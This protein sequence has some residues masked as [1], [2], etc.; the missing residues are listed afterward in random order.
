MV[1]FNRQ[2]YVNDF[3]KSDFEQDFNRSDFE[4]DFDPSQFATDQSVFDPSEPPQ[5][6]EP[7]D[8]TRSKVYPSLEQASPR[9]IRD[10]AKR[11][12]LPDN[13]LPIERLD[14][15]LHIVSDPAIRTMYKFVK[16]RLLGTPEV[17]WAMLKQILPKDMQKELKGKDLGTSIDEAL[18]YDPGR[19]MRF[20]G[21]LAELTGGLKT[22]KG[23]VGKM[24][25]P[26]GASQ[27]ALALATKFGLIS[28]GEEISKAVAGEIDPDTEFG[29]QGASM[30]LASMG[31]GVG[32]S[33]LSS[34]ANPTIKKLAG[35]TFG[36]AV[37]KA[38]Q[39]VTVK[40][41]AKWPLYADVI[42]KDPSASSIKAVL[43][44][45]K[46][47]TGKTAKDL[48]KIEKTAIKHVAR[49][50][51]R[52]TRI[53]AREYF[54]NVPPSVVRNNREA[55]TAI[56]KYEQTASS[57][58]KSVS[59]AVNVLMKS[60]ESVA[61]VT[62]ILPAD[63]TELTGHVSEFAEQHVV[64]ADKLDADG[65]LIKGFEGTATGEVIFK[66]GIEQVVITD[67]LGTKQTVPISEVE[68]IEQAEYLTID[69]DHLTGEENEI[70]NQLTS[71]QTKLLKGKD[72]T[73]SEKLTAHNDLMRDI[74]SVI[75]RPVIQD[76]RTGE[77][78]SEDPLTAEGVKFEDPTSE[79]ML[80]KT[81]DVMK[82][83]GKRFTP[84][85]ID[86][87]LQEWLK[88][89][90]GGAEASLG[91]SSVVQDA[92]R[93][94]V[95]A[96]L[97]LS[98]KP[99]AVAAMKRALNQITD[100]K[101]AAT[102]KKELNALK[103]TVH[104]TQK[105]MK[106]GDAQYRHIAFKTTGKRSAATMNKEQ[107]TEFN[108][109]LK[110]T[111]VT[112]NI[113]TENRILLA[114]DTGSKIVSPDKNIRKEQDIDRRK[115]MRNVNTTNRQVKTADARGKKKDLINKLAPSRVAVAQF[116]DK[117][118][119][120]V[121]Y[122]HYQTLKK[123]KITGHNAREEFAKI[124]AGFP[125]D[126]QLTKQ[127]TKAVMK[128]VDTLIQNTSIESNKQIANWLFED[129]EGRDELTPDMSKTDLNTAQSLDNI[130]QD[131][132]VAQESMLEAMRLWVDNGKMPANLNRT[133]D[134]GR[135]LFTKKQKKEMFDQA[136]A[137]QKAGRLS[138][139]S[140][141]M[142]DSGLRIG[143]RRYYYPAEGEH[144]NEVLDLLKNATADPIDS[145]ASAEALEPS[146]IS[147]KARARRGKSTPKT[148]SV[149]AN[150]MN[151]HEKTS[152]RNAV[153][154]D[155]KTLY[156]RYNKAPLSNKDDAYLNSLYSDV[157]LKGNLDSDSVM[158]QKLHA[159]F[160][161]THLSLVTN[162]YG[163]TKATIRNS[164]QFMAESGGATNTTEMLKT[165]FDIVNQLVR[166]NTLAQIDPQ[167]AEDFH[168]SFD[169]YISQ[170]GSQYKDAMFRDIDAKAR[171]DNLPARG[172]EMTKWLLDKTGFAY[173]G[174]DTVSRACLWPTVYK[175]TK[176][177][178]I[179][180]SKSAKTTKDYNKYLHKT[181]VDTMMSNSQTR[182][183]REL[184][185]SG[186]IRALSNYIAD[187]YTYDI[188][189]AYET[190]ERAGIERTRAQ[191]E[192]IGIYTYPRGVYDLFYNR[193]IRPMI[194]GIKDN[195][196]QSRA[197]ARRG[198][199]NVANQLAGRFAAN[200]ILVGLGLGSAYALGRAFWTPLSPALSITATGLTEIGFEL[201][202][203]GQ[204]GED[205]DDIIK[206]V[207]RI[208]YETTDRIVHILPELPKREDTGRS[209]R[210][211][212]K[213]RNARKPR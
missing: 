36:R 89:P 127:Q 82:E 5:L 99:K 116:E 44:E 164:L 195:T 169:S 84:Q 9:N 32:V 17:G 204:D 26:K 138:E 63:G 6:E 213:E 158:L 75:G 147:G 13:A 136:K 12:K 196:P 81:V 125:H 162:P 152:V 143:L 203:L 135:P 178:A 189:R 212:R 37:D 182:V 59:K 206:N 131:S 34:A 25:V 183:A 144:T 173:V 161:R 134:A 191:R 145:Y 118:S 179:E 133:D 141:Q 30:V 43:K 155:I 115:Q 33:Y 193:G 83:L 107:L 67:S 66:D 78:I 170:R 100:P 54:K 104:K 184:L 180:Y 175:S 150:I 126:K 4:R 165:G 148:G 149:F 190:T 18:G 185:S 20:M 41:A 120:P 19:V 160:W 129:Q 29:Y 186:D 85:Q 28:T 124:L 151:A 208:L 198:A 121:T 113:T 159:T 49:D 108:N 42:R 177:A 123:A 146:S 140:K 58:A 93:A 142:Y 128:G 53:T 2:D 110:S 77:F 39:N 48:T 56:V 207:A 15:A 154:E 88:T 87:G 60:E 139:H 22:V 65:N 8:F 114:G 45:I 106:I 163:A 112:S 51:D 55:V 69:R 16:G 168:N 98:K 94:E 95:F 92:V 156:S 11:P 187:T 166:G 197:R 23:T 7:I 73:N 130:L 202:K 21:G 79:V 14:R 97:L 62:S 157:L 167:M 91:V 76:A 50:I 68:T 211:D 86:A 199:F 24:G 117:T 40:I 122:L 46:A 70:A 72:L 101:A 96:R 176:D 31:A 119:I 200:T 3:N 103:S 209:E 171:A 109:A 205:T 111:Y 57:D 1:D 47:Y 71:K 27:K 64:T 35:T 153:S 137:A 174:V 80:M 38:A 132:I 181:N 74:E 210:E 102:T 201:S 90:E 172:V 52:F 188:F 105:E 192:K 194:E 10:L 61:K